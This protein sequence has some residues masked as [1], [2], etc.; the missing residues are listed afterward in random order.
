MWLCVENA[1]GRFVIER[2]LTGFDP[3]RISGKDP[4]V[5][6]IHADELVYQIIDNAPVESSKDIKEIIEIEVF[7]QSEVFELTRRAED[8]LR[9]IDEYVGVEKLCDDEEKCVKGL[10]ENADSI[11]QIQQEV[12]ELK[13]RLEDIEPLGKEIENIE[14]QLKDDIFKKHELWKAEQRYFQK[15]FDGLD[16]EKGQIR[17]IFNTTVCPE[18]PD[19]DDNSPNIDEVKKAETLCDKLFR[20]LHDFRKKEL[21]AINIAH[22]GIQDIHSEWKAEF[23]TEESEFTDK[24]MKLGVGNQ[25]VLADRLSTL[26]TK[27]FHLEKEVKPEY[28]RQK[29]LLEKCQTDRDKLL[30]TLHALRES[31]YEERAAVVKKMSNELE[32]GDVKIEINHAT[33]KTDFF[34]ILNRIYDGSSIYGREKQL[35]KICESSTPPEFADLVQ[36][37][38]TEEIQERLGITEDTASKLIKNASLGDLFNIQICPIQDELAIYLRKSE[39]EG[40]SPLSDLS[41]GEKC[42]AVFSIGL[43]GQAKPLLVDQ[44]EDE[45]DHAFIIS[46][47]V[48]HIRN[49]K[50]RR[51]LIISTHNANIPVLGDAELIF[52]VGKVPGVPKCRIEES[53]A[54]ENQSIIEKLQDLE[55]GP[56]AFQRRRQK[57]G[58]E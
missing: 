12:S 41:Y 8:Q 57:Y 24:L 1:E 23:D 42:T 37:G 31:I 13:E 40:F 45:L 39:Q 38:N 44:P 6:E 30:E 58:L 9:L 55:G 21:E 3:E 28:D 26:K 10:E 35:Q 14:E 20:E 25:K 50:E 47:I 56:K 15:I 51:Q 18:L 54:F 16:A 49:V 2:K 19:L 27:K 4:K 29:K 5:K 48:E 32:K 43:L 36:T 46:N 17:K 22:K 11:A 33:N 7:G 53:G 52:K 34:N